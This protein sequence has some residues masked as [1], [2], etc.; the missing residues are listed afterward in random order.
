MRLFPVAPLLTWFNTMKTTYSDG[1]GPECPHCGCVYTADGNHFFD[2]KGFEMDCDQCGKE[3]KV[4]P[5]ISVSWRTESI[6]REIDKE[7]IDGVN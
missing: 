5:N 2:D 4:W 3:F 7:R 1:E 6:E